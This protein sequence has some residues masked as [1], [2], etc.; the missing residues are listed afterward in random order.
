MEEKIILNSTDKVIDFHKNIINFEEDINVSSVNYPNN[1]FDAKSLMSLFCLDLS[2][3]LVV[4][5]NTSDNNSIK[6]FKELTNRF[7]KGWE[8]G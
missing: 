7:K 3:Q 5:I 1:I 2:K 8:Y 4:V 6:K